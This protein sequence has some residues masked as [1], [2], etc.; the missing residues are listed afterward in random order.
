MILKEDLDKEISKFNKNLQKF[1]HKAHLFKG[2]SVNQQEFEKNPDAKRLNLEL[3]TII[4][5]VQNPPYLRHKPD[6]TSPRV[7]PQTAF[8]A[9]F[10]YRDRLLQDRRCGRKQCKHIFA[11]SFSSPGYCARKPTRIFRIRGVFGQQG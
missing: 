8:L 9:R 11:W 7:A 6:N 5:L 10:R 3:L 1:R 4:L 2:G